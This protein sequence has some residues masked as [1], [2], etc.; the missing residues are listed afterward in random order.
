[1][2]GGGLGAR[3]RCLRIG[4]F[5]AGGRCA[6]RVGDETCSTASVGCWAGELTDGI[7]EKAE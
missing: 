4:F 7:E 5:E 1:M 3:I 2:G 6:G